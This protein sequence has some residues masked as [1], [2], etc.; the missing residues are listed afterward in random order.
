MTDDVLHRHVIIK[1][2][3]HICQPLI[4]DDQLT[5][6]Q[7]K[8]KEKKKGRSGHETSGPALNHGSAAEQNNLCVPWKTPHLPSHTLSPDARLVEQ[9]MKT[10]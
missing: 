3:G 5:A 8:R 10:C 7:K 6:T 4:D 1:L 9:M 2:G